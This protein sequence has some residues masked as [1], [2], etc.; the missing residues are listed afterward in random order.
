MF[1]NLGDSSALLHG[2]DALTP[3]ADVSNFGTPTLHC[4]KYEQAAGP[5]QTYLSNSVA[6]P[7]PAMRR[8]L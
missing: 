2:I 3:A 4:T 8:L 5:L 7:V 1:G 6:E